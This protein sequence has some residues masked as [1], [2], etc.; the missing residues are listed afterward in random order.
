MK[1]KNLTIF[2]FVLFFVAL[3]ISVDNAFCAS[4]L[5]DSY[6]N[7]IPT[8]LNKVAKGETV[9][10][11]YFGGSI[12][13]AGNGWRSQSMAKFAETYPNAKFEEIN[14]AIGGTGSDLGV[15]R[16]DE[17]VL[18]HDPDLVFVEFCVNDGGTP[19]D[20]I[21]RQIEG[22]VRK[23][24]R[25]NIDT[26]IVFVYTY[27]LGHENKYRDNNRADSVE[28]MESVANFYALPS[29][30]FNVPV[31][32]L[33][34]KGKL[35]YQ[36]ETGEAPE[37]VVVFSR[38]G[39][40]P[41]TQGHEIYTQTL[42]DAF[43]KMALRNDAKPY[44][45]VVNRRDRLDRVL[46]P[47]NMED[48]RMAK[49]TE[50]YLDGKWRLL[51]DDE[52]LS[53]VKSRLGDTV[54][55][56]DTPG[57]KVEILFKGSDL[58]IYDVLGPNGGQVK[59]TVDGQEQ[60]DLRPRFDHYCT[61][62]RVAVLYLASGLDPRQIHIVTVEIDQGEPDRSSVLQRLEDPEKERASG[63]YTGHN[64]WFGPIMYRGTLNP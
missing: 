16:M 10:I 55:T 48:A 14:A 9:R 32:D 6:R 42:I 36:Q 61:Y 45:A 53:W 8:F 34:Q 60:T 15:Y 59:I 25:H 37:G 39:V 62:W 31:V 52:P 41:L 27:R 40:H 4:V 5:Q 7:G 64:V 1:A 57:S 12:T 46:D 20:Q 63:K 30:D 51:G 47:K 35:I 29:I 2:A 23:I 18:K 13:E 19:H 3:V 24:W 44:P 50:K 26:D 43:K 33:A 49:L 38:D 28:A 58:A 56:S 54:Y 21:I 11:A 17:D 22:I